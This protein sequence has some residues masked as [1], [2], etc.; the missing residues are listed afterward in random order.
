MS[1]SR[2]DFLRALAQPPQ[3]PRADAPPDQREPVAPALPEHLIER[4]SRQL[5]LAEWSEA[6]QLRL[7]GAAVLVVGAGALGSPVAAYLAGAG[8]GRLGVA[9]LGRRARDVLERVSLP[10]ADLER[11]AGGHALELELRAHPRHRAAQAG[12]VER[13]GR[14]AASVAAAAQRVRTSAAS[15]AKNGVE[16]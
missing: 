15:G 4:Y 16:T 10:A 6:A 7:A 3:R 9:G 11:V 8:V 5:V 12:D 2:R 13:A 1:A 14:H